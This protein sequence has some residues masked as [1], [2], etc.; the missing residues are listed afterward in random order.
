MTCFVHFSVAVHIADPGVL[1]VGQPATLTCSSD[2]SVDMISSIEWLNAD[3]VVENMSI[4][5]FNPTTDNLNGASYTCRVIHINNTVYMQ[6]VVLLVEGE[7]MALSM[8]TRSMLA[9]VWH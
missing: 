4:L 1:T 5:T 9:L 8:C 2:F 3:S 6:R 7:L